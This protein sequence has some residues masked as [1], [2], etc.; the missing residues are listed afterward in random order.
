[1]CVWLYIYCPVSLSLALNLSPPVSLALFCFS[2]RA[3][4]FMSTR[5]PYKMILKQNVSF[6]TMPCII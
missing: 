5:F 2:R 6:D 1:M 3:P 4:E